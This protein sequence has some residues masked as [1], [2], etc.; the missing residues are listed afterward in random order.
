MKSSTLAAGITSLCAGVAYASPIVEERQVN[1]CSQWT[2][3]TELS[4]DGSPRDRFLHKQLSQTITC[5]QENGCS[6]GRQESESFTIGFSITSGSDITEWISGGFSVSE[7]WTTGN[8][9]TC[10]GG[11][12]DTVCIWQSVAHTAY[13]VRNGSYNSCTGFEPSGDEIEISSPNED[14]RGGGFY[15]VVG[16]CRSQ[17]DEYWDD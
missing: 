8:S 15:C 9:Y 1:P 17:G 14:N 10:N 11:A 12:G 5:D 6:V 2:P 4:G 3:A 13:K 7:S 16:T